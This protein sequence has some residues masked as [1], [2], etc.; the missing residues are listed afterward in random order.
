MLQCTVNV[1]TQFVKIFDESSDDKVKD[2]RYASTAFLQSSHTIVSI[3]IVNVPGL[4][5]Y[6]SPRDL[7]N[8]LLQLTESCYTF[9]VP[10]KCCPISFSAPRFHK[11]LYTFIYRGDK[12]YSQNSWHDA[13][14]VYNGDSKLPAIIDGFIV[15]VKRDIWGR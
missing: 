5:S 12:V 8:C 6:R 4:S 10:Y 11:L 3:A 15:F 14:M 7:F 1:T 13:V 9:W 2:H